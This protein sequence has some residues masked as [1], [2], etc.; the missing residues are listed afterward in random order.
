M[1]N[2]KAF[3]GVGWGFPPSFDPRTKGAQ[4]VAAEEDIRQSLRILL[5]TAPGERVMQPA[6]GCDLRRLV[7][8]VINQSTLTDIKDVITRAVL[9]FEPRVIV[10]LI[11][12]E[13]GPKH[14]AGELFVPDGVLRI[15]LDY[16]VIITNTRANLVY[17]FYLTLATSVGGRA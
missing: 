6:Y 9:L 13:A 12:V 5:A 15:K 8:E 2:D 4:T 7:F 10:D 11:T 3:L 17:D 14:Q 1:A 16:T